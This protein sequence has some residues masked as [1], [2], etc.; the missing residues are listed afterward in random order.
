MKEGT[1]TTEFWVSVA[2]VLAS[3]VEAM[4]GDSQ[5]STTLIICATVLGAC[6]ITSRTLVKMKSK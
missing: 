1:K 5:N 4:R 6:Y 2:P 3:L